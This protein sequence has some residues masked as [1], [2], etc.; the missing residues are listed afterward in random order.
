MVAKTFCEGIKCCHGNFQAINDLVAAAHDHSKSF[1]DKDRAYETHDTRK[2]LDGAIRVAMGVL[3]VL[4]EQPRSKVGTLGILLEISKTKNRMLQGMTKYCG[5]AV[6]STSH[7]C[8]VSSSTRYCDYPSRQIHSNNATAWNAFH[9]LFRFAFFGM[10]PRNPIRSSRNTADVE[11][12]CLGFLV[13]HMRHRYLIPGH[14]FKR[15][16]GKWAKFEG[17]TLLYECAACRLQIANCNCST[18]QNEHRCWKTVN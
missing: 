8:L 5:I 7:S 4:A 10:L 3:E 18:R 13:S 12:A 1:D 17:S 2:D 14:R 6:F 9:V 11:M 15:S 16:S